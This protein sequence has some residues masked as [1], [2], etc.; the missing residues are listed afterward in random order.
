MGLCGK[1]KKE[2][3]GAKCPVEKRTEVGG[4]E[5]VKNMRWWCGQ[6]GRMKV[7]LRGMEGEKSVPASGGSAGAHGKTGVEGNSNSPSR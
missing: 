5:R 6:R 7:R 4:V 1:L 3:R 2:R